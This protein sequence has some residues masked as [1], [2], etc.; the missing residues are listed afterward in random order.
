MKK[1]S[2][3]IDPAY[4]R[5][6]KIEI[7]R[8]NLRRGKIFAALII[9]IE[10]T[11]LLIA[12]F[13]QDDKSFKYDWYIPM[14]ILM[15]VVTAGAR[16][17]FSY[18]EKKMADHSFSIKATDL[19]IIIYI[20]FLMVWGAAISLID[21]ALYGNIVVFI[22]NMLL[23]SYIFY[24]KS[25]HI[26]IPQLIAACILFMGLPYFQS[27]RNILIGH[28]INVSIFWVFAWFM[29]RTNY[30]S[31]VQNFR[32]QKLIEEKSILLEQING[33]LVKEIHS[34][35][36]TQ[37]ELEAANEQLMTIS[38][39]DALTG[40]PNRRLLDELIKKQWAAAVAQQVPIAIMMID[41]DF[42]KLYNDTN[43]HLAG[44]RCLQAVARVLNGC[45]RGVNDFV[46]RF[47]GEEF[48][49]IAAD[50]SREETRLL[51]EKMRAEIEGL[52]LEHNVSPVCP[53]ITVSVGISWQIPSSTDKLS[54]CLEKADQALY[55]AKHKG[56]NR[57][58]ID[59][60]C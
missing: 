14:Y 17:G 2:L 20:I 28:Y 29:A 11:L 33:H 45:R 56:R 13:N 5:E 42:F 60:V 54:D 57:V 23:A 30:T 41:I 55:Q 34:R 21:Q 15:I 49:F 47:G 4:Q 16:L 18:L 26:L 40:I 22:V 32:N 39:M 38:T 46:A 31:Y 7:S 51:G 27:S 8:F 25:T 3:D 52:A 24:M 19:T 1:N 10:I 44:D 48:L 37:K 12:F 50:I 9:A 6:F 36:Q 35:E 53:Y 58:I 43:G 59:S